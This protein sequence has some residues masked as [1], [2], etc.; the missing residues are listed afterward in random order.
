M[1]KTLWELPVSWEWTEIKSLGEIVSGGTPS[2][3]EHSY[4]GDEV[5]WISPSDLTGYSH[6][7]IKKGA[8]NL[9]E[10]GLKNSS[11]KV[12]PKGS[13]HFSSRAPIG[14]VVIS[15]EPLSTNQGFKSLVPSRGI[16][17]EY[18]YYYL[19][20]SKQLAEKHATGTTFKEISGTAFG[21]LPIPIAPANEQKRIVTKIEELFEKIDE[22]EDYLKK[23]IPYSNQALGLSS[24]LRQSILKQAF[25]GNLVAQDPADEPASVLLERIK[26]EKQSSSKPTK[27][28]KAA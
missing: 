22:G 2:T 1:S 15:E 12:M 26:A 9:T 23:I 13:V 7:R 3:K 16:F 6:K 5:N 24:A 25:S 19:K 18:I 4:W 28:R 17:N 10:K 27:K 11:A 14:Y 21:K 8:K 20:A